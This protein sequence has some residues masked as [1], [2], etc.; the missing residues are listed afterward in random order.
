[1]LIQKINH[2]HAPK[3]S[4]QIFLAFQLEQVFQQQRRVRAFSDRFQEFRGR[5]CDATIAQQRFAQSGV[6]FWSFHRL[7]AFPTECPNDFL[8]QIGIVGRINR[9]RIAH[10]EAQSPAGE[11]DF[12]MTC[13]LCRFRAAQTTINDKFAWKWIAPRVRQSGRGWF[14]WSGN[15]RHVSFVAAI[16][17]RRKCSSSLFFCNRRHRPPLQRSL[18]FAADRSSRV[19]RAYSDKRFLDLP[20]DLLPVTL[21]SIFGSRNLL[22][23]SCG[24]VCGI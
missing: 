23:R 15:F 24:S 6:A 3:I 18:T 8:N 12:E 16:K 2:L 13:V 14:E 10:F 1:M 7:I 21:P 17:D 5:L 20:R 22:S 9:H 19:G 11:I 4:L